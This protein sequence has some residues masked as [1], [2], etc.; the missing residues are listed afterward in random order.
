MGPAAGAAAAVPV[1]APTPVTVMAAAA[2][3]T[4]VFRMCTDVLLARVGRTP[5]CGPGAQSEAD[6]RRFRNRA[7]LAGRWDRRVAASGVSR[8]G[9]AAVAAG[10]APGC[11][12]RSSAMSRA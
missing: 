3:T 12:L 8:G 10:A 9:Q 7:V 4:R 5:C 1:V 11:R 2:A 6:E